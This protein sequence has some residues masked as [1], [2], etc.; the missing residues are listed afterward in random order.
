MSKAPRPYVVTGMIGEDGS[1]Y[2]RLEIRDLI[3]KHPEQW[4][5]FVRSLLQISNPEYQPKPASFVEIAGIH[6]MPYQRWA[7][8]PDC[9]TVY[10]PG[11]NGGYCRHSSVLFGHWHRLAV[12][13]I[14]QAVGEV[15]AKIAL[16]DELDPKTLP[17]QKG[18]WTQAA[19]ELRFPFWDWLDPRTPEEGFPR[20]DGI[21]VFEVP[22]VMIQ[23]SR[24]EEEFSNPLR[25]YDFGETLPASFEDNM[26]LW[27]RTY[28]WPRYPGSD[29][30]NLTEDY[31][32]LHKCLTGTDHPNQ[33]FKP[34]SYMRDKFGQ[35]F[36][37][38]PTHPEADWPS[39]WDEWADSTP[40]EKRLDGGF[41]L[42]NFEECHHKIH[43]DIGGDGH[44]STPDQAAFEPL[45]FI[46]HSMVD[47]LVAMWEA[48]YPD[49]WMGKGWYDKEGKLHS[50]IGPKGT[51]TQEEGTAVDEDTPLSPFKKNETEYWTAKDAH[52]IHSGSALKKYFTYEPVGP[53]NFDKPIDRSKQQDLIGFMQQ[54]FSTS[55]L[56]YTYAPYEGPLPSLFTPPAM[57]EFFP[58]THEPLQNFRRWILFIEVV[59]DAWNGSHNIEI[60][61]H[62]KPEIAPAN[63]PITSVT[64]IA[65]QKKTKCAGCIERKKRGANYLQGI[66]ILQRDVIIPLMKVSGIDFANDKDAND[67]LCTY[68]QSSLGARFQLPGGDILAETTNL[69]SSEDLAKLQMMPGEKTPRVRLFS[70]AAV[71]AKPDSGLEHKPYYYYDWKDHGFFMTTESWKWRPENWH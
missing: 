62:D 54:Y 59:A 65:R 25:S 36:K 11:T 40:Q 38:P 23:T 16:A 48:V 49:Y 5:L 8:D 57:P 56:D 46:H 26:A 37:L 33:E 10:R 21:S 17:D 68:I 35:L 39:L 14:E 28:R 1:V 50:F 58:A 52:F 60:F 30:A 3:I 6:G 66:A 15:A 67:K 13:L 41:C 45:F 20:V 63:I 9:K 61:L 18:R 47:R 19:K 34:T 44:M 42:G 69:L 64:A 2:P 29:W 22:T 53:F 70:G 27:H 4:S 24:G 51:L 71:V 31:E 32:G 7:G 55:K 43:N 12:M